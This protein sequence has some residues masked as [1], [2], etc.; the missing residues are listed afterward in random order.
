[1]VSWFLTKVSRQFFGEKIIFSANGAE[2]VGYLCAKKKKK[3]CNPYF[4]LHMKI[5]SKQTK[6]LT[7]KPA[8][9]KHLEEHI[10]EKSLGPLVKDL[11]DTTP[12]ALLIR[13]NS[14]IDTHQN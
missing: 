14:T 12:K 2:T 6:D 1:M 3:N 5:N 4:T 9:I 7:V 13:K 8:A 11:L 10:R